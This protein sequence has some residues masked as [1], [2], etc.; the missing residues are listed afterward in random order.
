LR[1]YKEKPVIVYCESGS[2]GASA[3]RVLS[4]QGFK[5]AYNLRGGLAAWRADNLP[6]ALGAEAAAGKGKR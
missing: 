2:T 5:Q 6:L 1:K 3:A 4:G